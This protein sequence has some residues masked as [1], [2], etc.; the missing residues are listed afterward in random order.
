M[1]SNRSYRKGLPH[2]VAV[3]E[4]KNCSGQ[5]FDP[6]MVEIFMKVEHIF[7]EAALNPIKFYDEYSR[8]NKALEEKE[9]VKTA[10]ET[11]EAEAQ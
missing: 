6:Q 7:K 1:T 5:Q 9:A 11:Q 8:L 10:Q 4:I 2:E 3:E